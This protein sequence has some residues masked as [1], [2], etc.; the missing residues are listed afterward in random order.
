MD[1]FTHSLVGWALGQT[2]LKRKTRKG[3]AALVLGANA[4]DID[5]FF[6]WVP[7]A[8]L[9]IHRGVTH[10]LVVGV[11]VMPVLTAGFLWLLDRW[12]VGRGG[13]FKSGLEVRFGWLLA[14]A[15]LGCLTHPLL[16]WQTSYAVQL[17]SPFSNTW[18]HNDSLFIIDV[19]IWSAL[20]SGIWL[21]RRREKSVQAN[22]RR[23]PMIALAAVLAYICGNGVLSQWVVDRSQVM[24]PH[25]LHDVMVT[26]PPPVLFWKR[27]VIWRRD[28]V[29]Y[30]GRYDPF[31]HF[32]MLDNW[33]EGRP[34]G[35]TDPLARKVLME[36]PELASFRRWSILPMAWVKREKCTMTVQYQDARFGERPGA[37]RLG[38]SATVPTSATGC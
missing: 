25:A 31:Q 2:G 1:N 12:Q 32:G 9:A 17:L 11:W 16:D 37:G 26:S 27:D 15:F 4:P 30:R 10:S 13:A 24:E 29:I 5:V 34:D 8:P 28:G 35:M 14:L 20:S 18:F 33:G 22:W 21:S 36:T 3:L 38:T 23:P 6:G 7:W 19:W